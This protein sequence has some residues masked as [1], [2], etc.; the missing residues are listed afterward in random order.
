MAS[1]R[2]MEGQNVR[3]M[4]I[5][6]SSE[7]SHYGQSSRIEMKISIVYI[8]I[9]YIYIYTHCIHIYIYT[10]WSILI[11]NPIKCL[12]IFKFREKMFQTKVT[13]YE[14]GYHMEIIIFVQVEALRKYQGHLRVFLCFLME[15]S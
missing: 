7:R 12:K 1:F 15:L 11:H 4:A 2:D 14:G 3:N 6:L 9:V 8:Y 13:R 5:Y 10:G